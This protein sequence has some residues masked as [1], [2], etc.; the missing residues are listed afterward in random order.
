MG[1]G[2]RIRWLLQLK[3]AMGKKKGRG[4]GIAI[5]WKAECPNN[6]P[7]ITFFEIVN[8]LDI[9]RMQGILSVMTTAKSSGWKVLLSVSHASFDI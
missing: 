2:G 9:M 5:G 6:L 3:G 8:I 1:D 4:K 7:V